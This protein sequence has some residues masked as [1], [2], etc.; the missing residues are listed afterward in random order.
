S[1]NVSVL[2]GTGTGSFGAANTFA[3]GSLPQVVE[4]ADFNGDGKLDLVTPNF[5]SNNVSVLP[6][7]GNGTFGAATTFAAGTQPNAV[8]AAD[9]NGDGKL[10]LVA[11][12][13][14]SANVSM[15]LGNGDGTFQ[16][17]QNFGSGAGSTPRGLVL[18]DFTGDGQLD[19]AVTDNANNTVS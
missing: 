14:G 19:I 15:L 7:N 9:V 10:D 6:G 11:A 4:A 2:L 16:A 13:N 3:V 1:N 18:G 17:A 8:A 12:N 5:N